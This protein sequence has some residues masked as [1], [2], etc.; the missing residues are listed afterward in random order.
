MYGHCGTKPCSLTVT[1][2]LEV[3]H[4][5]FFIIIYIPQ[6]EV[7]NMYCF[8]LVL[9]LSLCTMIPRSGCEQLYDAVMLFVQCGKLLYIGHQIKSEKEQWC[10]VFLWYYNLI[11]LSMCQI[12]LIMSWKHSRQTLRTAAKAEPGRKA[13]TPCSQHR[14]PADPAGEVKIPNRLNVTVYIFPEIIETAI[15]NHFH[16]ATAT[17]TQSKR[18]QTWL[19][20]YKMLISK[21]CP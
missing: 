19:S 11:S 10:S 1:S 14:S 18:L 15:A 20:R 8:V 4:S 3:A 7:S 12:E 5:Q 21:I 9:K 13:G 16:N 2:L 17:K 6:C